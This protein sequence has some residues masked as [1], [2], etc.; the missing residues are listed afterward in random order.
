MAVAC[1]LINHYCRRKETKEWE[2]GLSAGPI[3]SPSNEWCVRRCVSVRVNVSVWVKE[4]M[5]V[6]KTI[7]YIF[8]LFREV[9]GENKTGCCCDACMT[10]CIQKLAWL[11]K[12]CGNP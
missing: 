8:F 5:S 6:R 12:Q 7:S 4:R 9:Q 1:V 3:H 2:A 11:T 10:M